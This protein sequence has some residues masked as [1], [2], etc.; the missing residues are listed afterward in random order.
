MN[1]LLAWLDDV[2]DQEVL[3]RM[4]DVK[5]LLGSVIRDDDD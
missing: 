4:D 5:V 1:A 2:F 3:L